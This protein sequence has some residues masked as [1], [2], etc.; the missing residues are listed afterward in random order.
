MWGSGKKLVFL[1]IAMAAFGGFG[2]MLITALF[3]ALA[4]KLPLV[5]TLLKFWLALM[6]VL[7]GVL[8]IRLVRSDQSTAIHRKDKYSPGWQLAEQRKEKNMAQRYG[9]YSRAALLRERQQA[10]REARQQAEERAGVEVQF[11]PPRGSGQGAD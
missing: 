3:P 1:G 10:E 2:L 8:F 6:V 7:A 4:I 9:G 11:R 5:S